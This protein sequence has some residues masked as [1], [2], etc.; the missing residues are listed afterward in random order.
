MRAGLHRP[1]EFDADGW[2]IGDLSIIRIIAD[3]RTPVVEVVATDITFLRKI[4]RENGNTARERTLDS[5][6]IG[7]NQGTTI[8]RPMYRTLQCSII[9]HHRRGL[10]RR[11]VDRARKANLPAA[12]GEKND[13]E[14]FS[15]R[16][17]SSYH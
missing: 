16:W 17:L 3:Y 10:A 11:L 9:A 14:S 7:S 13:G 5:P 15:P 6:L 4:D 2:S 8:F 1:L 12:T